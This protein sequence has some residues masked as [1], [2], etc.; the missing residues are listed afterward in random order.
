MTTKNDNPLPLDELASTLRA[1][2]GPPR[3]RQRLARRRWRAPRLAAAAA[4]TLLA[5]AGATVGVIYGAGGDGNSTV[6]LR[7][8]ELPALPS[9]PSRLSGG[10]GT[11]VVEHVSLDEM[12]ER[13]DVV[14]VG[15]VSEIGGIETVDS[16]S[17]LPF[18]THRVRY[19]VERVLRG[20]K[21]DQID[22]TDPVISEAAF[23]AEVDK[24][25]L[26]FA[27]WRELGE[28]RIRRLVPS[29]YWQ[30]VYEVGSDGRASNAANGA[31]SIDAIAARVAAGR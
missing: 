14:F 22:L 11:A 24:R 9:G 13:A 16:G 2:Q 4:A 29:G 17:P 18:P 15:R 1:Y 3:P 27:E 7:H 26:V 25:Y 5:A 28:A 6:A 8:V 30:G 10:G 23:P 12:I 31:V 21:V 20:K 19:Q